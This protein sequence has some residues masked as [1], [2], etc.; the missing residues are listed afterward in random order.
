MFDL[1]PIGS[2]TGNEIWVRVNIY[3]IM[4]HY[5]QNLV[6]KCAA[7]NSLQAYIRR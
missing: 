7:Y 4:G 5:L 1:T 3:T 6:S 2:C